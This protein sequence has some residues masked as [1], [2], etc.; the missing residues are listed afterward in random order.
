MQP[1]IST[2]RR[3][4][5]VLLV[6]IMALAGTMA[7]LTM[8]P[9]AVAAHA[10]SEYV[11]SFVGQPEDDPTV[12]NTA[13]ALDHQGPDY[14]MTL[15]SPENWTA[16]PNGI[17][18]NGAPNSSDNGTDDFTSVGHANP[19]GATTPLTMSATGS[20]GISARFTYER[21]AASTCGPAGP[22]V[23]NEITSNVAQI[24][25]AG[26]NKSQIKLQIG[27]CKNGS[28]VVNPQVSC[29]A[30]GVNLVA[31]GPGTTNNLVANSLVLQEGVTYVARCVKGLDNGTATPLTVLVQP[32][33]QAAVPP[34]PLTTIPATGQFSSDQ[35]VSVGNK[36][37][38]PTYNDQFFGQV[39]KMAICKAPDAAAVT[40]CL[41]T[42]VPLSAGPPSSTELVTNGS[43]E[44]NLSGWAKSGSG[45]P[46]AP[47]L[48]RIAPAAPG[49]G[50]KSLR[51]NSNSAVGS[52]TNKVG[53]LASPRAEGSTVAGKVYTGSVLVKPGALGQIITLRVREMQG[54]TNIQF[55]SAV[56]TSITASSTTN[57]VP[58]AAQK[59]AGATGNSIH[60]E[61]YSENIAAGQVFNADLMS[62]LRQ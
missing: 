46:S 37:G 40:A 13:A 7:A 5:H 45:T 16:T 55:G 19:P 3:R 23:V 29:R 31:T 43:V 14:E 22:G 50:T 30:A 54:A 44:T 33:G 51:V 28:L 38:G 25:R 15:S 49:G 53:F 11:Y 56:T 32:V 2:L 8:A 6:A 10:N 42:E 17:D 18:F 60:F 61:V 59:T 21:A 26:A 34:P 48:T 35:Y 57:W 27:E 9:S 36:Y 1:T 58:M 4:G 39:A 20:F 41:D 12:S 47:T 24:G 62:L 52:G